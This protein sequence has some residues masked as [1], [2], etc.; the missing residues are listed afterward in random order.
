MGLSSAVAK[1]LFPGEAE[2]RVRSFIKTN[3]A[4]QTSEGTAGLVVGRVDLALLVATRRTPR[5]ALDGFAKWGAKCFVVGSDQ[6][7]LRQAG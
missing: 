2:L 3:A 5:A 7:L 6:S 1:R 4:R